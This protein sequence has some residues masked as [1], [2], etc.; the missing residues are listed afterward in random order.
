SNCVEVNSTVLTAKKDGTVTVQAKVGTTL[1]NTI[2]LNITWVVDGHVLPPEPD[3]AVNNSTLLGVDVNDNGVR[4]DV[5]RWIYDRY[6][7]EHP[8]MIPLKMQ[9]A[10]AFRY[11]IQDPSQARKRDKVADNAFYCEEAFGSFANAFGR[12]QLFEKESEIS[13]KE[14]KERGNT[15]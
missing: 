4:D 13:I 3:P 14:D 15:V 5:E 8:I 7:N 2:A 11:I 9:E 12:K 1:S 6:K 10:R